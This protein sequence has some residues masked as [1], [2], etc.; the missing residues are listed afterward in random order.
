[1]RR[2]DKKVVLITGAARGQGRSH[3]QRFAEEGADI[4]AVD[5]CEPIETITAYPFPSEADLA[6]T[7]G[8]V[9]KAGQR[10][11]TRKVDVRDLPGLESAVA[12]G[13]EELGR[14]DAVVCNAGIFQLGPALEL[15]EE[16]WDDIIA[17]NL[18][19][20]WKTVKAAAPAMIRQGEG[21]SI[22]LISSL[23][24]LKGFPHTAH[25]ASSKHGL[26]GLMKVLANELAPEYIRVNAVNPNSVDTP[27]I[28][29]EATYKLFAPDMEHPTR[30]D[31]SD[32][33]ASLNALPVPFVDPV[34]VSNA[35]VYL[36]SDE[37]RYVTGATMTVDAGAVVV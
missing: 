2:I 20:V 35:L 29:N 34:D 25:Y 18:T 26:M 37:S 7:A 10:C 28:Q 16:Q 15:T 19:G 24:G 22:A 11:F 6:E 30:E 31:V 1:M 33:F 4:I 3:A 14:L 17:V 8:L 5:R 21:G 27:M 12:D 36:I 32:A 13:I 23:A 9:E